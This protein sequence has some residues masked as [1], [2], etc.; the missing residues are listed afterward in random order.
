MKADILQYRKDQLKKCELCPH[1]YFRTLEISSPAGETNAL[2]LTAREY[3]RVKD[4]LFDDWT[5]SF[6]LVIRTGNSAFYGTQRQE[7][8]ARILRELADYIERGSTDFP[9]IMDDNG[10]AC[11]EASFY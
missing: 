9:S 11:G 8:T 5:D 10:N 7:E 6:R 3:A 2:N 4:V 1:P